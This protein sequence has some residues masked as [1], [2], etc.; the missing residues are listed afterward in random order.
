MN[1]SITW[2]RPRSFARSI[3]RVGSSSPMAPS[4]IV[5]TSNPAAYRFVSQCAAARMRSLRIG[6]RHRLRGELAR[7]RLLEPLLADRG[8]DLPLGAERRVDGPHRDARLCRDRVDAR[9]R[10][11]VSREQ[12]PGRVGDAFAGLHRL[13]LAV[14][15]TLDT[16]GHEDHTSSVMSA[17]LLHSIHQNCKK[18]TV[19]TNRDRFIEFM[20]R[21]FEQGDD[22]VVDDLCAPDLV[23]HQFGLAGDRGNRDR[24][25]QAGNSRRAQD[26]SGHPVQLRRDGRRR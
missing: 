12:H 3:S 20:Q 8:Q 16:W 23:E 14:R 18:V 24:A 26:D 1:E 7:P 10:V 25:R 15:R 21:G 19:M 4:R 6:H 2:L 13:P 5:T 22:T 11:A 9:R 17:V